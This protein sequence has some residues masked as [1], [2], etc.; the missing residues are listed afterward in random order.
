M[1]LHCRFSGIALATLILASGLVSATSAKAEDLVDFL[2]GGSEEY[3][4]GR[5]VVSFDRSYK[6]N[7]IIVS[8]SD[9]RLYLITKPGEAMRRFRS[10]IARHGAIWRAQP[11]MR[12]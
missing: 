8:F 12:P 10:G 7:Q 2:W 4:G 11:T 6:P 3:G 9:R 5:S 1:T